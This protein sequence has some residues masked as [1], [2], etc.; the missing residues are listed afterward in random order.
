[1]PYIIKPHNPPKRCWFDSFIL[2]D[3]GRGNFIFSGSRLT[4]RWLIGRRVRL[5]RVLIVQGVISRWTLMNICI[6][7]EANKIPYPFN[8]DVL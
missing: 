1:M 2:A 3:I 5:G 6:I 4:L 7:L 8:F